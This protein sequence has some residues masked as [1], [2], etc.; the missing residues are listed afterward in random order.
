MLRKARPSPDEKQLLDKY[1]D[2]FAKHGDIFGGGVTTPKVN[3]KREYSP[4][5]VARELSFETVFY[6]ASR[7]NTPK[8]DIRV[9]NFSPVKTSSKNLST[10]SIKK[11]YMKG[12]TMDPSND[13][14]L[15]Q[16]KL[17]FYSIA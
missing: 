9:K 16:V 8:A 10:N 13:Q 6:E 4:P 2:R 3:F 12:N 11:G 17:D 7:Q 15:I 14:F 1:A 5:R